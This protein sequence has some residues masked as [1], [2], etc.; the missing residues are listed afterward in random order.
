MSLQ[1]TYWM[2]KTAVLHLL[3]GYVE[4]FCFFNFFIHLPSIV[5]LTWTNWPPQ[6]C[7]IGTVL[8]NEQLLSFRFSL[9][10]LKK[11]KEKM[12]ALAFENLLL[13]IG[14][15]TRLLL[16]W[17]SC[18][19]YILTLKSYYWKSYVQRREIN[20]LLSYNPDISWVS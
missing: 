1:S 19:M 17:W 11:K 2:V 14:F 13:F 10:L 16:F 20:L 8:S 3:L 12:N 4:A 6:M 18:E 9:K 15:R 5:L 7:W